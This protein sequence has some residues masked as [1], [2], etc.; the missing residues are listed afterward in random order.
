MAAAGLALAL[1]GCVTPL[2]L[3]IRELSNAGA[4]RVGLYSTVVFGR[5]LF[6]D[7][8][9]QYAFK[10][11]TD[12]G[13]M[14]GATALFILSFPL[15]MVFGNRPLD[16]YN[17]DCTEESPTIHFFHEESGRRGKMRAGLDGRFY[18]TMPSGLYYISIRH[19]RL[20]IDT[21]LHNVAFS[22]DRTTKNYIG[23]LSVNLNN[24]SINIIDE[25]GVESDIANSR[26]PIF[27]NKEKIEY[28][29]MIYIDDSEITNTCGS[30]SRYKEGSAFHSCIRV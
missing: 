3:P 28:R 27:I 23:T 13:C 21:I 1:I 16:S 26:F 10:K 8:N 24:N 15:E 17:P 20:R 11:E 4:G 12:T 14:V 7:E 30:F 22:I 2:T 5:I 9:Q 6:V 29:P 18:A 19:D 25:S